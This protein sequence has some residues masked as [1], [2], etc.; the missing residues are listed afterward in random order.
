MGVVQFFFFELF[1]VW[2]LM[3]FRVWFFG[4]FF[5]GFGFLGCGSKSRVCFCFL[6]LT[7]QSTPW[8]WGLEGREGVWFVQ[9]RDVAAIV[10]IISVGFRNINSW[11]NSSLR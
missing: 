9:R 1:R 7:L 6:L 10:K 11:Q 2:V 3:L 4:V 5:L 8:L